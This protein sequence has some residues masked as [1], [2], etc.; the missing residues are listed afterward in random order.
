M[1]S[2]L[3]LLLSIQFYS[4]L[5]VPT[6][7]QKRRWK[8]IFALVE[9]STC[10]FI[11]ISFLWL[12]VNLCQKLLFLQD[13]GRICCVHKLFLMSKSISVHNMFSPCSE[14]GISTYWT[15]NLW[16]SWCKNKSFWQRFT[17]TECIR[18]VQKNQIAVPITISLHRKKVW[19]EVHTYLHWNFFIARIMFSAQNM[20]TVIWHV[21]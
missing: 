11:S 16:V 2:F 3:N 6:D 17:C 19:K 13:M 9:C 8:C 15:C 5:I 1:S 12:Q 10:F 18:H 14:L 21:L 20:T 4:Q 7:I